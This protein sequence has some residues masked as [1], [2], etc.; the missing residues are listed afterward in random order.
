MIKRTLVAVA[1]SM[2]L[3]VAAAWAGTPF[4]EDDTGFV[5]PDAPNGPNCQ[6]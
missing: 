1:V 5:P 6:M 3:T 4:G 2:L